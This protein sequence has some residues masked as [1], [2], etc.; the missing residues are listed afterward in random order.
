M[1]VTAFDPQ[2]VAPNGLETEATHAPGE[3][4]ATENHVVEGR[5][6]HEPSSA[7]GHYPCLAHDLTTAQALRWKD[8]REHARGG[9]ENEL[10]GP[11]SS[12]QFMLRILCPERKSTF[13]VNRMLQETGAYIIRLVLRRE[14]PHPVL[15]G[16]AFRE[17]RELLQ[18]RILGAQPWT[19]QAP[20]LNCKHNTHRPSRCRL[21]Q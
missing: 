18:A 12:R 16:R 14:T 1:E 5:D 11:G 2:I 13:P 3:V 19:R 7:R 10:A 17:I 21:R 4:H 9:V 20:R 8:G 6:L 15:N